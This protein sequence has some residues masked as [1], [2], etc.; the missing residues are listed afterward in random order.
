MQLSASVVPLRQC[1]AV[2]V[3]VSHRPARN[4]RSLS[5]E[6]APRSQ[7]DRK[8]AAPYRR[9]SLPG[10]AGLAPRPCLE[11]IEAFEDVVAEAPFWHRMTS[12]RQAMSVEM[13]AA[14]NQRRICQNPAVLNGNTKAPT[15][16]HTR[17]LAS[18]KTISNDKQACIAK[19]DHNHGRGHPNGFRILLNTIL[20]EEAFLKRGK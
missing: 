9:Q 19:D 2:V 12:C 10:Y 6:R 3:T 4:A 11:L 7:R 16:P 5:G 8:G 13:T 17:R 15:R 18:Q 20:T 14:R 1:Y